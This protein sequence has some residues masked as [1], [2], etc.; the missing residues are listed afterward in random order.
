MPQKACKRRYLGGIYKGLFYKTAIFSPTFAGHLMWRMG[1]E[2]TAPGLATSHNSSKVKQVKIT[3][4]HLSEITHTWLFWCVRG[5]PFPHRS[6]SSSTKPSVLTV[7]KKIL[8]QPLLRFLEWLHVR[9]EQHVF[10]A[11]HHFLSFCKCVLLTFQKCCLS[12]AWICTRNLA[13]VR[14]QAGNPHTG[15]PVLTLFGYNL[16]FVCVCVW[17]MRWGCASYNPV[18]V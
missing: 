11:W 15:E 2:G 8:K 18:L 9:W 13:D 10:V 17:L 6:H 16:L 7:N 5:L 12:F 14:S 4:Y 3:D 1:M